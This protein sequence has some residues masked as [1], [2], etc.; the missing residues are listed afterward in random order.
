MSLERHDDV[1]DPDMN[2]S[3][4]S[5]AGSEH[6]NQ[7]VL[8]VN[9]GSS[10]VRFQVLEYDRGD[11][12]SSRQ[13]ARGM[14]DGVGREASF[15]A[16]L[17]GRQ[18]FRQ[19]AYFR[20]H[21]AAVRRAIKWVNSTVEDLTE[22]A[23]RIAAVGHRVVHGGSRFTHPVLIN[24]EVIAAIEAL[25]ELAPLHNAPSLAGIH[26]A[27]EILGD[28]VPMAA[29]FDTAFHASMPAYASTYALP[30]D[31]A[32]RHGI[33]RFGFHGISYQYLLSRYAS[34]TGTPPERASLVA[35]HLGNGCSAA[36]M[37]GGGS[38][39]TSMG[40][41]PLEGLV[42]GTRSG[43]LDPAV[44]LHLARRGGLSLD[45]VEQALNGRSGLLGLS[46]L[47]RDMRDLLDREAE[48]PQARLAVELFCYRAKKYLG[49]YLAAL[50]G[51]DAVIFSGG[52]GENSPDVRARICEG[53]GWCG[54]LIDPERNRTTV[55]R[56]GWISSAESRIEILV[57]PS[58][59]ESII[60][61]E[62]AAC[63]R[64]AEGS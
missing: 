4:T 1:E 3:T 20:D 39:D 12:G 49:A 17:E 57:I 43:D 52:I 54:L 30:H 31:L 37:R 22:G 38:I 36:A 41:T 14:I 35:F 21:G 45:E 7:I 26:A 51:A 47:S 46:G 62:T 63:L 19:T 53:M 13:L 15:V 5:G 61:R 44:V 6:R 8:A 48:D 33:R 25:A 2:A 18:T 9:C 10:S 32:K 60:G 28:R 55:G 56:E 11:E 27:R 40:F 24:E 29:V 64:R 34:L 59:E 42:M 23:T 50:G 58:D 16:D